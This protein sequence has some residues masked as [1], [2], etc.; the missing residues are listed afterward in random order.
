MYRQNSHAPQLLKYTYAST[1]F[2][3]AD[4]LLMVTSAMKLGQ[5][6]FLSCCLYDAENKDESL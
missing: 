4:L 2:V 5:D 1:E 3:C 6:I